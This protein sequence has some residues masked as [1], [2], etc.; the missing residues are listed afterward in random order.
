MSRRA[1][2]VLAL[3]HGP[4]AFASDWK[5]AGEAGDRLAFY[6]AASA[7]RD[8]ER[9]RFWICFIPPGE[10]AA[11]RAGPRERQRYAAHVDAASRKIA[12]GY[13]PP[14]LS[15]PA[16]RARHVGDLEAHLREVAT[17]EA[18]ANDD[19][20]APE[21]LEYELDCARRTVRTLQA[22]KLDDEGSW[23]PAPSDREW[24]PIPADRNV[25]RL[26]ELLCPRRSPR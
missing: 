6:D 24:R 7:E 5:Y 26:A 21:R 13:V 2:V 25:A 19:A 8:G 4:A 11:P 18:I 17:W 23:K 3:L 20:Y 10:L 9:V 1:W 14:L 15:L 22:L 12:S 16:V